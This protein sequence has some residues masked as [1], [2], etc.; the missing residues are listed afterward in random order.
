[1]KLYFYENIPLSNNTVKIEEEYKIKD[2]IVDIFIELTNGKRVAIEIQHSKIPFTNLLKR[3][4]KYT[5]RGIYVLWILNGKTFNKVPQNQ[6]GIRVSRIEFELFKMYKGRVYYL[7][8]DPK[9]IISGVYALSYI[10][11][12]NIK[13]VIYKKESTTKRSIYCQEIRSLG[14]RFINGKYKLARFQDESIFTN[15]ENDI[16]QFIK[17]LCLKE[18]RRCSQ[19][20]NYLII[21]LMNIMSELGKKYGFFLIYDVLKTSK[22]KINKIRIA[23]FGFMKDNKNRIKESIKV[24]FSDY[25][26][27][28]EDF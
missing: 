14:L 9:G 22:S 23:R 10:P 19:K 24:Y 17:K 16:Y 28:Y 27:K 2:Q 26:D 1:M 3:T 18:Y 13:D 6:D 11:Y 21:P 12:F 20:I 15:C 8:I 7:N 4:L 25:I 5:K